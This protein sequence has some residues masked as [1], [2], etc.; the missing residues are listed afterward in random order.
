MI[1]DLQAAAAKSDQLEVRYEFAE[2]RMN[3]KQRRQSE[4]LIKDANKKYGNVRGPNGER[5]SLILRVRKTGLLSA[6]I[7]A[8]L[9]F[10]EALKSNVSGS[11]QAVFVG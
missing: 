7:E 11:D 6:Q 2:E 8:I 3:R 1:D 4:A 10:P 5:P 9:E